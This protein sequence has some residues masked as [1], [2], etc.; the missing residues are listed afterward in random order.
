MYTGVIMMTDQGQGFIHALLEQGGRSP[1]LL[2]HAHHHHRHRG[3]LTF[4][5]SWAMFL[6]IAKMHMLGFLKSKCS[7]GGLQTF[8]WKSRL[9][10]SIITLLLTF[11]EETLGG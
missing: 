4:A 7:R 10:Y 3:H 11:L 6:K 2:Q 1:S 9:R 8:H 5:K